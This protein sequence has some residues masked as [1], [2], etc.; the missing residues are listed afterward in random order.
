MGVKT[1]AE[2]QSELLFNL[3]RV[4]DT[5]LNSYKAGWI[6]TAYLQFCSR[7]K[8]W[9]F[10]VPKTF[11]LPELDTDTTASGNDGDAHITKPSNSLFVHTVWDMTNDNELSY[12]DHSWYVAQTGRADSDSEGEPSYWIPYGNKLYL[13]PTLDD[14]YNFTIYY[15]KRPALLTGTQVTAIGTEWDEP[16]LQLATIQSLARLREFDKAKLW[17]EEFIDTV[18]SLM[19][20]QDRQA[21]RT[22]DRIMPSSQ[23]T[24]KNG[25]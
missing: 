5:D 9:Y 7:N 10:K 22:R 8:F 1:F 18:S 12:K 4:T 14:E 21:R 25:Y 20:L 23:H 16:I 3:G 24:Q 17:K 15:R 19:G 6:N 11:N 2:F 13:Y